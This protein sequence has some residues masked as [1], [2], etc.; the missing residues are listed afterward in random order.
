MPWFTTVRCSLRPLWFLLASVDLPLQHRDP[1][2]STV[3]NRGDGEKGGIENRL[4]TLKAERL[5]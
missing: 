2:V 4:K 1:A 3:T 5:N